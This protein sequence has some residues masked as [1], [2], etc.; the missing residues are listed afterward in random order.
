MTDE[1][2]KRAW[3]I[4]DLL[5]AECESLR[6]ERDEL[7]R[8]GDEIMAELIATRRE[9]DAARRAVCSLEADTIDD[10]REYARQVGWSY[11]FPAEERIDHTCAQVPAIRSEEASA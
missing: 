4:I 5:R 9:R 10:Q 2:L 1:A 11:L 3:T 6:G 7:D 8:E